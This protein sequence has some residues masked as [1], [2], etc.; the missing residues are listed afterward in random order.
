LAHVSPGLLVV[1]S[2]AHHGAAVCAYLAEAGFRSTISRCCQ[3]AETILASASFNAILITDHHA[4]CDC[5]W[6]CR[7][8]SRVDGRQI[9]LIILP[10]EISFST[11]EDTATRDFAI[12]LREFLRQFNDCAKCR[13]LEL[14]GI[15][16]DPIADKASHRGK[17]IHL[18][19]IEFRLLAYFMTHPDQVFTPQELLK[20]V[21][22]RNSDPG[23]TVAMHIAHLR[24][25]LGD[26]KANSLI[27]TEH[28]RVQPSAQEGVLA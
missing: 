13:R 3:K 16:L 17:F 7:L 26:R 8:R 27:D 25:A 14:R 4:C 22:S 19:P 28:G 12:R 6:A 18:S 5:V 20:A 1:G 23:R 10:D 9:P 21:W 2:D 24:G 11:S 15:T